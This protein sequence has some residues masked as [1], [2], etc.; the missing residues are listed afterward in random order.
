MAPRPDLYWELEGESMYWGSLTGSACASGDREA[1]RRYFFSSIATPPHRRGTPIP[2]VIEFR[3]WWFSP[4]YGAMAALVRDQGT[5]R[6]A[7]F[8][9]SDLPPEQAFDQAFTVSFDQWAHSWAQAA[10]GPVRTGVHIRLGEF[11]LTLLWIGLCV[12][13]CAGLA[14]TRRVV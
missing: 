3:P 11:A 4:E 5:D 10:Y 1:C 13:A 7:K 12:G 2:G 9:R 8:W 14:T 6:F